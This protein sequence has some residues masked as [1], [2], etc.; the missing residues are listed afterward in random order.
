MQAY[1]EVPEEFQDDLEVITTNQK[2]SPGKIAITTAKAIINAQK[3]YGLS[4][5]QVKT[6][7][8]AAKTD[9]NFK[10]D[11]VNSYAAAM[12]AGKTDVIRK[13]AGV[14]HVRV[15]I[16]LSEDDAVKLEEK[17]VVDGPCKSLAVLFRDIV[18]G[19]RSV[20]VKVID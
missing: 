7:F 5:T 13:T 14:R 4:K 10:Y 20:R 19:K 12:K 15:N 11:N 9:E 1:S 16:I 3:N 2:L 6:L 18:A 8:K 17:Y